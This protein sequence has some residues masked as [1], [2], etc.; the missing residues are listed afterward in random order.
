MV[1]R[2]RHTNWDPFDD[3]PFP[4]AFDDLGEEFERMRRMM[5]ES[6]GRA[7]EEDGDGA[8]FYGFSMR[9]GPDG[10]AE[11]DELG[12]PVIGLPPADVAPNPS[13]GGRVIDS[14]EEPH[15]DVIECGDRIVVEAALPGVSGEDISIDV[16]GRSMIIDVDTGDR[17]YHKEISFTTPVDPDSARATFRNGILAVALDCAEGGGSRRVPVE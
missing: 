3:W 7:W 11:I 4:S 6:L 14:A 12:D 16:S 17:R 2:R 13:V 9:I 5:R 15:T 1:R 8:F 10:R